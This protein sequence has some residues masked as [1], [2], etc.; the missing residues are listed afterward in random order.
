MEDKLPCHVAYETIKEWIDIEGEQ[1]PMLAYATSADPDTMYY[2]EAM[3]ESDRNEFIKAM[4][5]AV[6]SQ[7][8]KDDV[9]SQNAKHGQARFAPKEVGQV[10]GFNLHQLLE[11]KSH[12]KT[13][14]NQ[15][16]GWSTM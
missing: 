8:T 10:P 6:H 9:E 4:V 12:Q 15:A 3:R 1:H 14:E 13:M 16:K 2:H 11:W 7:H 5:K